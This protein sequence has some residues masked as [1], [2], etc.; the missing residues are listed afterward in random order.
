MQVGGE[1]WVCELCGSVVVVDE[2]D[3]PGGGV[4]YL[5]SWGQ[6]TEL[7]AVHI[8]QIPGVRQE[9][10]TTRGGALASEKRGITEATQGGTGGEETAHAHIKY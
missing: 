10:N 3:P 2:V 8:A 4:P 1:A 5:P 6:R 9:E 7:L